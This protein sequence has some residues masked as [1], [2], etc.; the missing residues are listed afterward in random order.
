MSLKSWSKVKV[1]AV[2]QCVLGN[3]KNQPVSIPF[4]PRVLVQAQN[5]WKR[6]T[7]VQCAVSLCMYYISQFVE[8]SNK[9][10]RYLAIYS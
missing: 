10:G 5:Q 4:S 8:C 2:I 6:I 3:L 7:S 9:K 1:W